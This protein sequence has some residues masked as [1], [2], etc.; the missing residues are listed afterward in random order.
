[1][2]DDG[3]RGRRLRRVA[4][5]ADDDKR[6]D[7]TIRSRSARS[8]RGPIN[9]TTPSPLCTDGMEGGLTI[10]DV[11]ELPGETSAPAGSDLELLYR[12]SGPQLW[13]AIYAFA[14]GRR[15]IADDAVAE[16]F[17]RAIE[18]VTTIREPLPW[19]YRT[20][21][22]IASHE[23]E[24]ERRQP[25]PPPLP[26]PGMDS[27]EILDVLRALGSLTINQRASVLLHDVEGFTSIEIGRM[28]GIAAATA[29]VHVF[30]GRR[31]LRELLRTED[32][33]DA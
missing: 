2:S 7:A 8:M 28:L 19:I 32:D 14:G 29:R 1:M 23:L 12:E 16:A 15:D 6:A 3:L 11:N 9:R 13:R 24:R 27:G 5:S 20:A 33:H 18:R 30:N 25:L 26:V 21:F 4:M 22:R 31:R 17:A 10:G